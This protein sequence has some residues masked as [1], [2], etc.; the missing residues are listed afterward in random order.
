M[1]LILATQSKRTKIIPSVN[2]KDSTTTHAKHI[3]AIKMLTPLKII[4]LLYCTH[5]STSNVLFQEIQAY[6]N[7]TAYKAEHANK[8]VTKIYNAFRQW[9]FTVTFCEFTYFE[10]RILKYTENMEYGYPVV[11]LNGCPNANKTRSK[12]KINIHGQ[13]AYVI[14]AST[15][16]LE[17]GEYIVEALLRTGVFKPRSIVIFII[18]T[19]IIK[20]DYFSYDMKNHFQ[21]LWSRSI[22]NSVVM[23]IRD[24][25][26]WT[27][28]YNFFTDQIIDVTV[29]KNIFRVLAHQY[30]NL[31]GHELRLSVYSKIYME[32]R[33]PAKCISRLSRTVMKE[34]NATCKALLPRDGNT[35][36]DLMT[37]GT[38]TGVTKDLMDGYS[39][40]ELSSRILKNSYYGYIDTTYPLS[41]DNLC[42]LVKNNGKQSTFTTVI[43]LITMTMLVIFAANYIGLISVALVVRQMEIRLWEIKDKRP[44][45]E[46][47]V[48]LA[49]CFIRQTVDVKFPGFV[50]RFIIATIIIYSLIVDCVID[51]SI[52]YSYT[53]IIELI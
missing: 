35:V 32:P 51:V 5:I 36:G 7:E 22:T 13:T 9:F 17:G 53:L 10:N 45:G 21:L 43:H 8:V 33:Q 27:Y 16:T 18:N 11:L 44:L 15:L 39:D 42:F 46:T 31:H 28:T 49:K 1:R 14:T 50:Y 2:A 34:L 3:R 38:A 4:L 41:Q 25:K 40:L 47:I 12:P 23:F 48:D 29:V 30:D 37:N 26:L 52:Y 19:P 6:H 20:D 24:E